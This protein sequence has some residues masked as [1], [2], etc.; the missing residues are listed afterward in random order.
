MNQNLEKIES[1]SRDQLKTTPKE[2]QKSQARS[3]DT[4]TV[5]LKYK[6]NPNQNFSSVSNNLCDLQVGF[7]KKL[8]SSHPR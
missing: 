4:P 7:K 3:H 1:G 5:F 2:H 6:G 8:K